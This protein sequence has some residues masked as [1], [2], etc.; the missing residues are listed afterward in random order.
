VARGVPADR[1]EVD[2][3]PVDARFGA[4]PA[5]RAALRAKLEVA[6][7]ARL[8]LVMGGGLGMGPIAATVRALS[9]V[10]AIT[11]VV[12]VG[13]NRALERRVRDA[14]VRALGFVDNVHEW[15]H[16]ADVL[17]TKPGG[18]TVSEALAATVTFMV[19]GVSP[20]EVLRHAVE[21]SIEVPRTEPPRRGRPRRAAPAPDASD[22][23]G[24]RGRVAH[25]PTDGSGVLIPIR[26]AARGGGEQEMFLG[27]G[28]IG[29][30]PR[31]ANLNGVRA[32]YAIYMVGDSMEPRYAQGWLLHVNPFKPP[33]HE[34]DVVVFK[35]GQAVLIKQFVRWDNDALV[36][37]QLNPPAELKIPREEV[38]ECHL[39]VG[40]DQEG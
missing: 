35:T 2:G 40:V 39:V 24:D 17:I 23:H 1:I 26:S 7:G 13:K 19:D 18:L 10:P 25:Q 20:D 3:I 6:A 28:P 22:P 16:A 31:P 11:P 21:G 14:G 36:L 38:L 9:A 12:L 30:T 8:A 37:Y 32:A 29:Y 33:T 27:D 4:P 5:D 15:M 34:R